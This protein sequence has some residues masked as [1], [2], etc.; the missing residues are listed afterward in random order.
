MAIETPALPLELREYATFS[1]KDSREVFRG[2]K[3]LHRKWGALYAEDQVGAHWTLLGDHGWVRSLSMQGKPLD[4]E[5]AAARVPSKLSDELGIAPAD[6]GVPNA[7]VIAEWPVEEFRG[8]WFILGW[9]DEWQ[10]L[11]G[12]RVGPFRLLAAAGGDA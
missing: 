6:E 7:L 1:V 3:A 10:A 9:P 8:Q 12:V 2:Q 11:G 5:S 4:A